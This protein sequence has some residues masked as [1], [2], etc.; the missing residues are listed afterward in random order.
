MEKIK[1]VEVSAEYAE[2]ILEYRAEFPAERMRVTYDPER[3]PGLDYLENYGDGQKY[4]NVIEWLKFC[5]EMSDK[6]T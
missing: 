2:K 5:E 3:I 4:E 1:L 6:I